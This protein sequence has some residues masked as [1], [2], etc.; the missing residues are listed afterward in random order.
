MRGAVADAA[1]KTKANLLNVLQ[2]RD[3]WKTPIVINLQF[4]QANVPELPA[5]A[6]RFSQ[7]G[8]GLKIQIDLTIADDFD[9]LAVRRQL[10]RGVLLELM[11]RSTPDLPAGSYYAE[12]PDWLIEGLLAADP[13]QDHS[14]MIEAVSSLL[15]ENKVP[16]VDE[17][18]HQLQ[19][20]LG[21]PAGVHRLEQ[22]LYGVHGVR[23]HHG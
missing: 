7:T 17:F 16:A 12:A 14:S 20:L 13:L 8:S 2:T 18:L 4:P 1:E 22:A 9:V 11:Y 3:E 10:L 6:L 5:A 19:Q 23:Q 21:H 15:A